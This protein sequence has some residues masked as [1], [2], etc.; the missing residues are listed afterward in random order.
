[1]NLSQKSLTFRI[2]LERKYRTDL[3][4]NSLAKRH[5]RLK[6]MGGGQSIAD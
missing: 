2:E 4:I 5:R 3:E 6:S 1:M